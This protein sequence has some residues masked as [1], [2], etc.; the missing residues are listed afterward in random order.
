MLASLADLGYV[1]EWRVINAAEYG[2]PQRR[3]RT[4]IMGYKK[5]TG[6]GKEMLKHVN[7][8]L[9]WMLHHG[10]IAAGFP[11]ERKIEDEHIY[12]DLGKDALKISTHFKELYPDDV[13]FLN[14]GTMIDGRVCTVRTT[15]NYRAKK[16]D[17]NTLGSIL[18]KAKDVPKEYYVSKEQL[19]AEK[20]WI[21][22]KGPKHEIRE[23]AD[24][25]EYRY[26]EG[27]MT[28]PDALDKPSRTIITAEGGSAPSRF[29]HVIEPKKGV[30][31]RLTPLELERLCQFPDN[32]TGIEGMP[33]VRRA[34]FM[35][36]ALVVG[37]V[38][39]MGRAL[40]KKI[41]EYGG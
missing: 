35:G 26:D 2:K 33:D 27:G 19:E 18:I 21:Y 14:T 38:K 30:F 25:F 9:S 24:G 13:L 5:T 39:D 3:K 7:N 11:V 10:I 6:I 37:I 16:S 17:K 34:F 32:H 28:F 15:P 8:P 4:F 20:G 22:L 40:L 29:K 1:V 41:E 12:Y 23:T 36:N 31:R